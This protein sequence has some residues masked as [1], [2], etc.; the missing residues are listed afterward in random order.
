MLST[1]GAALPRARDGAGAG[2]NLARHAGAGG[3]AW[4]PHLE[5]RGFLLRPR[6]GVRTL[7]VPTTPLRFPWVRKPKR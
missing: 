1:V 3:I 4:S 2:R 6:P 5:P 7:P